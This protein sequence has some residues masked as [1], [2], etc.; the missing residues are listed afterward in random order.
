MDTRRRYNL[1]R[2]IK[3]KYGSNKAY[4]A[5]YNY[6]YKKSRFARLTKTQ[7]TNAICTYTGRV[8]LLSNADTYVFVTGNQ[9]LNL[10]SMLASSPE[11][12]TRGTQYSYYMLNG[13]AVKFTRR[14]IDPLTTG[15]NSFVNLVAGLSMM[16]VNFYPNLNTSTV[17]A[18][19]ENADSSWKVSPFLHGVQSHY[20]PF[21]KN[22]TTGSNSNGLGVWNATN[23][24]TNLNGELAIYNDG[25]VTAQG[26]DLG[27]WDMEVNFYMSLCNNTGA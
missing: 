25:G 16:S 21:P 17:G 27:I 5:R 24:Y 1:G 15:A 20:Q 7:F 18:P 13:I 23:T 10:S 11:F 2:Y 19:V 14:W 26:I 8:N 12:I 6:G 9:Y 4:S 22:F 3:K